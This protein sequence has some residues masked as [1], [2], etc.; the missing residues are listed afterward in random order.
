MRKT[1]MSLS[2]VAALFAGQAF[3][4]QATVDNLQAAGVV[5]TA[6]QTA[7][8]ASAEG[9]ALI[10]AIVALIQA[11]PEQAAAIAG[12]AANA[13]PSMAQAIK[14]AATQAAPSQADAIAAAVAQATSPS[15]VGSSGASVPTSSMPSVGGSGGGSTAPASRN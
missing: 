6:E 11:A 8:I 7:A 15:A 10:D 14:A 12:A 13:N 5:M 9:Q 2:V 4:D 3:A 1:F